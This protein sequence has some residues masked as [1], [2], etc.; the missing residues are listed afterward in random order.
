M[1]HGHESAR[2]REGINPHTPKGIPILRIGVLMDFS[3]FKE[4]LQGSKPNEL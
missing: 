2:E 1:P 4:R 3:M